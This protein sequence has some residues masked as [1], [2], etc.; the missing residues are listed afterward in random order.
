MTILITGGAGFIGANLCKLLIDRDRP[1]IALDN[2]IAGKR[3]YLDSLGAYGTYG[4]IRDPDILDALVQRSYAVVHLAALPGIADSI[5]KPW[6]SF[7]TNVIGSWRLLHTAAKWNKHLIFASSNAVFGD[8]NPPYN[9]D[10]LTAPVSPYGADKLAVET[11]CRALEEAYDLPMTV[12]RFSNVYGPFSAHKSSAVTQ[13]IK[14]ALI[15][16]PLTIHGDGEQTRDF[17]YVGDL[18]EAIL[19]AIDNDKAKGEIFQ[20]ATGVETSIKDLAAHVLATCDM[21]GSAPG[22]TRFAASRAGDVKHNYSN[23]TKAREV[24]DW[25]PRTSL[26]RGIEQTVD[27]FRRR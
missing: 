13:F 27:W 15:V 2:F 6:E 10:S 9:E 4:D 26:E 1:F 22:L 12:L 5:Y 14:A 11:Y 19:V 25:E 3:E 8:G 7:D 24:L 18:C 17:I 20:I 23:I 21:T 16:N